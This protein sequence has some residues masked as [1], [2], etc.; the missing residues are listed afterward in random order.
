MIVDTED[1]GGGVR[2]ITA[3]CPL[4]ELFGYTTAL[5]GMSQGRAAA[6]ME[7]LEYRP[8]ARPT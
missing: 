4:S 7:F 8:H 5:R 2:V 1:R 6:S 3:E